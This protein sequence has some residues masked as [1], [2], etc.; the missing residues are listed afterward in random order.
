M[1]WI[2]DV[3]VLIRPLCPRGRTAPGA[4]GP[5]TLQSLVIHSYTIRCLIY[6]MICLV[7][8]NLSICSIDMA[9]EGSAAL[10][11]NLLSTVSIDIIQGPPVGGP[12]GAPL[13]G[14]PV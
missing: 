14:D 8:P 5:L 10:E 11:Y 12:P 7:L 13:Q 1:R 6:S 4:Q 2:V 9:N 3:P